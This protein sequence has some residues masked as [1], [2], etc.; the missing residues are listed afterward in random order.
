MTDSRGRVLWSKSPE[1]SADMERLCRELPW[2]GVRDE[3]RRL[4]GVELSKS[5]VKNFKSK[6]GIANGLVGGR[7]NRGNVPWNKGRTWDELGIPPESRERSRATCFKP[8]HE[9]SGAA[10][11]RLRPVGSETLRSD[12]FVWVKVHDEAV[13]VAEYGKD[14]AKVRMRR[15]RQRSH[16]A[17]E[18]AHGAIP[19]GCDIVHADG[20]P[21]N[22]EPDNL[23]AVPMRL[24]ATIAKY[25]GPYADR[26]TLETAMLMAEVVQAAR[27]AERVADA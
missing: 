26:E 17:Y 24:K 6:R 14:A 3:M 4:W 18:A 10:A 19:E 5:Q 22:D 9:P 20:N 16:I 21:T 7:F 15:W 8:R 12:G 25:G 2:C 23:V 27:R 13:S 11:D 1:P